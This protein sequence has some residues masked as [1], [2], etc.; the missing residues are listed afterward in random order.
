MLF[1]CAI[2]FRGKEIEIIEIFRSHIDGSDKAPRDFR[3]V[4]MAI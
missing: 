1:H 3:E 2:Q 4:V